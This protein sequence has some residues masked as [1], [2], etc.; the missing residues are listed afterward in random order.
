MD[1]LKLDSI[2]NI[3]LV[4]HVVSGACCLLI[5]LGALMAKKG[6]RRHILSG[7]IF[8]YSMNSVAITA[9]M[10]S[11]IRTNHFLLMV[12]LFSFYLNVMGYRSVK[13]KSLKPSIIDWATI[14]IGMTN[15]IAMAISGNLVLMIFSGIGIFLVLGDIKTVILVLKKKKLPKLHWL[16]SHI[17]RMVGAYIATFTAFLVVNLNIGNIGWV[18]WILPSLVGSILIFYYI[19]K[20]TKPTQKVKA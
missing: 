7:R 1:L 6:N 20:F 15:S 19:S 2:F 16:A 10:M 3:L 14:L 12:G 5:G 13:N 4:I 8:F 11:L 17:G 9:L 18:L